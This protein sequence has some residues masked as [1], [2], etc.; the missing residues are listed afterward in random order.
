MV[1][2]YHKAL[3]INGT[4]FE[5]LNLRNKTSFPEILDIFPQFFN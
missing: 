2:A 5:I 1:D 3:A 4:D